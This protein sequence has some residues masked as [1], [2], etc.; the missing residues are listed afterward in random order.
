VIDF[1]C[2]GIGD[3]SCDLVIAWTFLD[4]TNRSMF[5]SAVALDP[6]TWKRARGWAIWKA[7]ITLV[8]TRDSNPIKAEKPRQIIR[9]ILADHSQATN[10]GSR[11]DLLDAKVAGF[12]KCYSRN[13]MHG[14]LKGVLK[15]VLSK[16]LES[17]AMVR[18]RDDWGYYVRAI[19]DLT[20]PPSWRWRIAGAT[21]WVCCSKPG[22]SAAMKPRGSQAT[23]P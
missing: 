1:G 3:P 16:D 11:P 22:G 12:S 14:P 13:T 9:D 20:H 23:L 15:G 2:A 10:F 7:L 19:R 21:R 8:Q 5:R 4:P 17:T 18:D 6:A